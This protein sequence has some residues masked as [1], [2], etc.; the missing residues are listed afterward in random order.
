[1]IAALVPGVGFGNKLPLLSP[2]GAAPQ[3][4]ARMASL[5]LANFNAFAFDFVLRQKLQ[6]ENV[7]HLRSPR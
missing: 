6:E 5:L 3:E 7:I 4:A 1:M 2:Q